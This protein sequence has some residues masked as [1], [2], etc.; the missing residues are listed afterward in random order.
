M[1]EIFLEV[2]NFSMYVEQKKIFSL[3]SDK[4]ISY[5]KT[6]LLMRKDKKKF[7]FSIIA[8]INSDL[9]H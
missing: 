1:N 9:I 6:K 3:W 4:K 2:C 8:A 7:F 5:G